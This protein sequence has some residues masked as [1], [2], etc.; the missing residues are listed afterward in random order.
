M[1]ARLP[2]LAHIDMRRVAVGFRH[3]RL[4][5]PHGLQ[6]SLTPLRFEGGAERKRMRGKWYACPRVVDQHGVECLYLLSF[7]LPRLLDHPLEEKLTTIAHELWHIGPAMNGDL[8]RH[9]GRCYAHGASARAFDAYASG[10]ARAWL[11]RNPPAGLYAF[12][13]KSHAELIAEHGGVY[14][15]RYA[16]PK[17]A[18]IA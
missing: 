16:V 6:A 11:G 18:P 7:Y 4:A 1:A 5:T 10:L 17:L 14:G 12:L 9:N 2:E 3:A 8:R 13:D 15:A